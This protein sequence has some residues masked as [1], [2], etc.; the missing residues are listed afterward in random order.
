[1]YVISILF[2]VGSMVFGQINGNGPTKGD[3]DW[4]ST[5]TTGV[6]LN[7]PGRSCFEIR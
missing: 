1:M 2:I 7:K 5:N 3:L 4:S 6:D